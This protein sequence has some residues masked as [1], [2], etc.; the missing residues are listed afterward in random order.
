MTEYGELVDGLKGTM[1]AT[2]KDYG[3]PSL[4]RLRSDLHLL[5]TYLDSH[6]EKRP[7]MKAAVQATLALSA[8]AHA[9]NVELRSALTDKQYARFA[10]YL[11]LGAIGTLAL[12]NLLT[13]EKI[14]IPRLLLSGLSELLVFLA[15]REYV[16]AADSRAVAALQ[17]WAS[18]LQDEVWATLGRYRKKATAVELREAQKAID[19][20]FGTL[21]VG[22]LPSEARAAL[23]AGTFQILLRLRCA[24]VLQLA[25]RS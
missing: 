23:L 22:A 2:F 3:E 1:A 7:E 9:L 21:A 20:F 4:W 8:D 25:A 15:S 17:S 11:D 5:Q 16:K 24:E 19:G 12:D 13:A 6:G 14:T 10:S 18:P